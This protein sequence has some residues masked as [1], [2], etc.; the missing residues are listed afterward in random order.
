MSLFFLLPTFSSCNMQPL[1]IKIQNFCALERHTAHCLIDFISS[2]DDFLLSLL[3][4]HAV[5]NCPLEIILLPIS[6]S[7]ISSCL[8]L[9][10][11]SF[12]LWGG[13]LWDCTGLLLCF[14]GC[15]QIVGN[16]L[17]FSNTFALRS[18]TIVRHASLLAKSNVQED[19][20]WQQT[21]LISTKPF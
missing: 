21:V 20:T 7:H 16:H 8:L 6:I 12:Q 11:I 5:H 1:L 15:E 17:I 9:V 2:F 3:S 14:I 13:K 19:T 10:F 4:A 18:A